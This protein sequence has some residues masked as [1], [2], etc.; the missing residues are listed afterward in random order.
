ME[1]ELWPVLYRLVQQVGCEVRQRGVQY[2]PQVIALVV[3]WAAL[4][5]RP[6]N[7]ACDFRNWS[8]T[9]TKYRPL[10]WP[11]ESVISRRADFVG[12]GRRLEEVRRGT[13]YGGMISMVDGKPLFVGGCLKDP[14]AHW[15][16]GAGLHG[17][18]YRLHTIWRQQSL[19]DAWDVTP[20]NRDE[21]NVAI[22]LV[23]HM[24]V[25]GYLLADGNYDIAA[26][27][28][29][30][31][32]Q[33]Y[34][35][36]SQDRRRNA[37]QGHRPLDAS[38]RRSIELRHTSFGHELLSHRSEIERDYGQA[39]SFAGGLGP[40]PNWGRRESRVR[41]WVWA[42]LLINATPNRITPTTCGLNAICC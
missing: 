26:L 5:N 40:L 13:S 21:A 36:I 30:A 39:T 28:I 20:L 41:T 2:Q 37:G 1:R 42:K 10:Q 14:D 9:S 17:N 32:E 16:Y 35:L 18:G 6:R 7:W 33:G 31:H 15:G 23:H 27:H 19:P 29:A 34:Q 3:Q 11:S 25:G 22:E 4:H 8:S 38:R 12:M 24:E